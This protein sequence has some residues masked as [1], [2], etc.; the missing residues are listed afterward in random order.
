MTGRKLSA[1]HRQNLSEAITEFYRDHPKA[2]KGKRNGF[3]GKKHSLTTCQRMSKSKTEFYQ[4]HPEAHRNTRTRQ[5]KF[6]SKKNGGIWLHYRSSW[7]KNWYQLLEKLTKVKSYRVEPVIVEYHWKGGTHHYLP[8]LLVLYIDGTR[9]LVEVKPG[10][11]RKD[12]KNQAKFK[13]ARLWC[14]RCHRYP[15]SFKVVGKGE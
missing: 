2:S 3:F 10:Y 5:G 14:A 11:R 13:A 12:S 7:E 4:N 8:D 15:T 6:F 1:E 9:D